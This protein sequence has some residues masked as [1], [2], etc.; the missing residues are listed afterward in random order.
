MVKYCVIH[1]LVTEKSNKNFHSDPRKKSWIL[2]LCHKKQWNSPIARGKYFRNLLIGQ[3][4]KIANFIYQS[5]VKIWIFINRPQRKIAKF[6]SCMPGSNCEFRQSVI[7]RNIRICVKD[8][9]KYHKIHQ[10]VAGLDRCFKK[11]TLRKLWFF[12]RLWWGVHD[13]LS[14]GISKIWILILPQNSSLVF[15]IKL[16]YNRS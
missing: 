11:K 2:S 13:I 1:Q 10:S 5:L 9:R 4:K 12:G 14:G 6:F 16:E 3:G 7:S 8:C 15:E